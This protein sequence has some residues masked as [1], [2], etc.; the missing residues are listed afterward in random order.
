M[1]S[2]TNPPNPTIV[3]SY[4]LR[5]LVKEMP[6]WSAFGL[7]F[8]FFPVLAREK[9]GDQEWRRFASDFADPTYVFRAHRRLESY[10]WRI[11]AS[12][13]ELLSGIGAQ[14]TDIPKGDDTFETLLLM[15][16]D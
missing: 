1:C 16:L 2:A 10:E 8:N 14:G 13:E 11:P 6:F 12:D 4:K 15:S 7:W 5:S 3:I 9:S